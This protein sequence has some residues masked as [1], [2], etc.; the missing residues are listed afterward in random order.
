MVMWNPWRGCH[1]CSEGCKYC[2]IH[3]GDARKGIDTNLIHK[4]KRFTAPIERN[5]HGEYRMKGGQLVYLCFSSDFLLE[6][7]DDWRGECWAMIRERQDLHFLFLTKRIERFMDRIPED[8]EAGYE[9]VT[10]GCTVENQAAVDCKLKIFQQL[11]IRHRNIIC[12][13]LLEAVNL[14]PYLPG[15]E[16]VVVGGES[17]PKARVLNYDWVL[18]IRE[19]CI[20]AGVHFSFRQCGTHFIKNGKQYHLHVRVL[21]SQARKANL[22]L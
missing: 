11:P 10:V 8:W 6:E 5:K 9:N 22:D 15:C 17:D 12:Q 21:M 19:Q 13:P 3:K 16:L 20:Q 7:A 14:Q 18:S 1:R 2:Y 4:T